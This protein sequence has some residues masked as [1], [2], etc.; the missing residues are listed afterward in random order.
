M[1]RKSSYSN[2]RD[3]DGGITLV[4]V[5]EAELR[6]KEEMASFLMLGALSRATGS[7]NMNSQSS[8]SHAIF[9]I[10][11]EQKDGGDDILCA[12][13]HLVDLAGSKR[14]KRTRA[15]GMRFSEDSV[16]I[17]KGLLALGNVTSALGNEKKR[18]GGHVPY[19][20]SKLTRLLQDSLGR[21][22]KTVMIACVSSANTNAEETLNTLKFANHAHN[23]QNKAFINREVHDPMIAQMQRMQRQIEQLQSELLFLRGDS[24]GSFEELQ[25]L[26]EE[27]RRDAVELGGLWNVDPSV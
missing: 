12:K 24:G 17:N 26:A 7:T 9:T 2:Q 15:D 22:S 6:T 16:D 4:C 18:K 5:T 13:L 20:D 14:A 25:V 1:T 23:I 3:W 27:L 21:N 10:S 8:H 19:R 11:M